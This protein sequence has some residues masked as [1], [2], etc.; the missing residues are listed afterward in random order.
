MKDFLAGQNGFQARTRS[1]GVPRKRSRGVP[2]K[3]SRGVASE[4]LSRRGLEVVNK[5]PMRLSIPAKLALLVF[6]LLFGASSAASAAAIGLCERLFVPTS[7]FQLEARTDVTIYRM[8]PTLIDQGGWTRLI[9]GYEANLATVRS[10][11]ESMKV[12]SQ[13][14]ETVV[15]PMSGFDLTAFSRRS[16]ICL[17]RQ[18]LAR[19]DLRFTGRASQETFVNSGRSKWCI[20]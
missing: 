11:I 14:T 3:R 5:S 12:P 16:Q 8:E 20:R 2:R 4:T 9:P 15:Y 7:A 17:D 13:I 6:G 10:A 1:R 19:F 18:S